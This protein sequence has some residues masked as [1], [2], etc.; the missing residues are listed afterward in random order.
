MKKQN[1][2]LLQHHSGC[3]LNQGQKAVLVQQTQIL[4]RQ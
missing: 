3:I 2:L 1:F 4:K